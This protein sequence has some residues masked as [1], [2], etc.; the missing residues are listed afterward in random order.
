MLNTKKLHSINLK[1]K[2]NRQKTCFFTGHRIFPEAITAEL[3]DRLDTI[4]PEIIEKGYHTFL[5]GGALGFD[6]LAA[7][8][9]L[10]QRERNPE[11]RLIFVLPCTEHTVRWK[12][13]DDL[14]FQA[15]LKQAGESIYLY[16]PYHKYCLKERN[17]FMAQHAGCCIS[18]L[19][20]HRQSG[21]AQAVR[22]AIEEKIPVQNLLESALFPE[23]LERYEQ[24]SL[25]LK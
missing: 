19:R 11:L 14:H 15:L 24:V 25:K 2:I 5:S 9:V 21:T 3:T 8:A 6:L 12:R 13:E 16:G 17:L 23:M 18:A 10:R 7:Q 4:L 20:N 22:F 1:A